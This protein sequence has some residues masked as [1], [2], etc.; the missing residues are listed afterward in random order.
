MNPTLPERL[1]LEALAEDEQKARAEWLGMFRDDVSNLLDRD[2][3]EA[4]VDDVE[5]RPYDPTKRYA[6][7][8]DPSGGRSDSMTLAVGHR[9]GD[10]ILI[11]CLLERRPTFDPQEVCADF[12][13]ALRRYQLHHCESDAYSAEWIKSAFSRESIG[14]RQADRTT[15]ESFLELLPLV[16]GRRIRFVKNSRLVT[17][18]SNLERR[19]TRGG[20]EQVGHPQNGGHD[21]LA[22][23]VA[24]VAAQLAPPPRVVC[25]SANVSWLL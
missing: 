23:A 3:V 16:V 24:G 10:R 22:A 6:A 18:L 8:V 21:D 19:V 2:V 12:A 11:D 25:A 5:V 15:S 9:D 7:H 4:L 14:V 17:Q 13:S 20:R 1:V